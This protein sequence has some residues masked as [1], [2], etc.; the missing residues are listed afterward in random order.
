[1]WEYVFV[2]LY[3]PLLF[4]FL[5]FL[6]RKFKRSEEEATKGRERS[7]AM[8]GSRG[9]TKKSTS[10]AWVQQCVGRCMRAS[11]EARICVTGVVSS[12]EGGLN[13]NSLLH[14]SRRRKEACR[15]DFQPRPAA[16]VVLYCSVDRE[17]SSLLKKRKSSW[18]EKRQG[19]SG[20]VRGW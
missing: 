7:K 5:P 1:M 17:A 3:A 19:K 10:D 15:K 9:K 6:Y 2:P 18:G 14:E 16:A 20:W 12:G 4:S 8:D 13:P 11:C